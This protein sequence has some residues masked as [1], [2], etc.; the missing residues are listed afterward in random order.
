MFLEFADGLGVR[1]SE[2]RIKNGSKAFGMRNKN[3]G[4]AV[5]SDRESQ[6][7]RLFQGKIRVGDGPPSW[8]CPEAV[9]VEVV[10]RQ[11]KKT[12]RTCSSLS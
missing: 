8:G 7:G 4:I 3:K 9:Q 1:P 6:R 10:G 12:A 2:S 5:S 11:L